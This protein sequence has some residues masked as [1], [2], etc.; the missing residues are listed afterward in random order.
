MAT[1]QGNRGAIL[2]VVRRVMSIRVYGRSRSK[3]YREPP[4]YHPGEIAL[5]AVACVALALAAFLIFNVFAG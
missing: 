3:A 1:C 4:P 5:M 2:R